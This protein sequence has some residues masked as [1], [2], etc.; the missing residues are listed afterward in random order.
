MQPDRTEDVDFGAW[1]ADFDEGGPRA[2]DF[3][4]AQGEDPWSFASI[5]EPLLTEA[6]PFVL[7]GHL[8]LP[9]D[10]D[11]GAERAGYGAP[12][13]VGLLATGYLAR[14]DAAEDRGAALEDYRRSVRVGL[15]LAANERSTW[16]VMTG[17][18]HVRRGCEAIVE[19]G[20]RREDAELALAAALVVIDA[21]RLHLETR[22][23]T[24]STGFRHLTR[25][26]ESGLRVDAD[27]GQLSRIASMALADACTAYRI[28]ALQ[29]LMLLEHAAPP[30]LRG[31]AARALSMAAADE[32]PYIAALARRLQAHE[33]DEDE[34]E[35]L[36]GRS[37]RS[38]E[39]IDYPGWPASRDP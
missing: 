27:A 17:I 14:G 29:A 10:D 33:P 36:A 4:A 6:E 15:L 19:E 9:W 8:R 22:G 32:D 20:L 24:D 2:E 31:Q 11:S 7:A 30:A 5:D 25:R 21:R 39:A 37:G 28:D 18:H 13:F 26:D 34:L 1:L 3:K 38:T 16:D 23:R 12:A 35:R